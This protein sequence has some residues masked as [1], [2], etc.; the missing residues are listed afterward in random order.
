MKGISHFLAGL[1]AATFVP[2]VVESAA[3]GSYLILLGGFFGLLPDTLD[4]KFARYF[5]R[6]V[7]IDPDPTNLDPQMIASAV[8]AEIDRAAATNQS[9]RVQLHN[10]PLG[11]NRWR[12]YHI[13]F[14][15]E[16]SE[17]VVGIGPIV[18][19]ALAPLDETGQREARVKT[20]SPI[21]YTYDGDMTVDIFNGPSFA[22]VP[23]GAGSP[24][25]VVEVQ[26]LPW[27][28]AWSHS[29]T[30][31]A[32]LGLIVAV[33]LGS[34]TAGLVA[35]CGMSAHIVEDQLGYLGSNLFWPFTKERSAGA[36]LLHS[37][38]AI[39]NFL[40][41]WTALVLILFNLDRFS[42][43]IQNREPVF[44]PLIYFSTTLFLP[45]LILIGVYVWERRKVQVRREVAQQADIVA[46]LKE[47]EV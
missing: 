37:G 46:E 4:F 10:I 28:R 32:L 26:F 43:P 44:D 47:T 39:P 15:A 7:N 38:D 45:A 30:L 42:A 11:P 1:A 21:A 27:H 16:H 29:F 33:L 8:T 22:F 40:A 14:D 36:R 3:Q 41:V 18:N 19:S 9:I 5:E 25:P 24:C 6:H 13:H 20:A 2:G 17:V 31:A 35:F 34:I 23:V 12:Q